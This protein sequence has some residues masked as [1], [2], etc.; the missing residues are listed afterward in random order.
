VLAPAYDID[1]PDVPW[2]N[3]AAFL[4][5]GRA[6]GAAEGRGQT[7]AAPSRAGT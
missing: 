7:A 6:Y 5:A 2:H 3:V 1:E 4:D